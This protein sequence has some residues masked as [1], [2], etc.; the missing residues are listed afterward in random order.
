V[1][2]DD[3]SI[4]GTGDFSSLTSGVTGL[5]QQVTS[6]SAAI[7]ALNK[8]LAAN[9]TVST[10]SASA[11]TSAS[12]ATTAAASSATRAASAAAQVTTQVTAQTTA[13]QASTAAQNANA[14][15]SNLLATA[16]NVVTTSA[17]NAVSGISK[18]N[19]SLDGL[20]KGFDTAAAHGRTLSI[21]FDAIGFNAGESAAKLLAGAGAMASGMKAA[22]G[23]FLAIAAVTVA[24]VGI[25]DF[26]KNS[27]SAA[28]QMQ[29]AMT[30]L[31]TAIDQGGESF[32]ALKPKI[33]AFI[34]LQRQTTTSD[35]E[36]L[37]EAIT[38]LRLAGESTAG[39]MQMVRVAE[40]VAA[41]TG[42]SLL[43]V[44]EALAQAV[45][46]HTRALTSMNVG[47]RDSIKDGMSLHDVLEALEAQYGGQ[48]TSEV[49][50]YRGAH[51][52]LDQAI[53]H[54]QEDIG[55]KLLD[56]LTK[57]TQK[58]TE[59]V[60]S[61]DKD[62]AA[63]IANDIIQIANA[64]VT[65]GTAVKNAD[66]FL[67]SYMSHQQQ[68]DKNDAAAHN[69]NNLQGALSRFFGPGAP[70]PVL[71]NFQEQ[72]LGAVVKAPTFVG[73]DGKPNPGP[74][75]PAQIDQTSNQQVGGKSSEEQAAEAARKAHEA[76]EKNYHDQMSWTEALFANKKISWEAEIA[77]IEKIRETAATSIQEQ[78]ED[79]KMEGEI[80]T[81]GQAKDLENTKKNAEAA[82][83][84]VAT[85]VDFENQ[86]AETA[87]SRSIAL[88]QDQ[89]AAD[90][91]ELASIKKITEES[92]LSAKERSEEMLKYWNLMKEFHANE[93]EAAK[94]AEEARDKQLSDTEA[95]IAVQL[96]LGTIS[97]PQAEQQYLDFATNN[98]G[99]G[100]SDEQLKLAAESKQT[101]DEMV[102]QDNAAADLQ[103]QNAMKVSEDQIDAT[104]KSS[105]ARLALHDQ[106][107]QNTIDELQLEQN[108]QAQIT[109]VDKKEYANREKLI[110]EDTQLI[111]KNQAEIA[112]DYQTYLD[113]ATK[114]T[115]SFIDEV[116]VKHKT[117]KDELQ[118]LYN[119][120]LE[121]YVQMIAKMIV[122]SSL[123]KQAFPW[124]GGSNSGSG[125]NGG[126][127]GA[128][129]SGAS[130]KSGNAPDGSTGSP[131]NVVIASHSPTAL[132]Q[133]TG[134]NTGVSPSSTTAM[135]NSS[136]SSETIDGTTFSAIAGSGMD[137]NG[138]PVSNNG[139]AGGSSPSS[140]AS[141][142]ASAMQAVGLGTV[143]ASVTGGNATYGALGGVAGS[144][145]G[146][147]VGKLF[148]AAGGPIGEIAGSL[149][150][151]VVGGLF[152]PHETAA[153]QPDLNDPT[154][155]TDLAN[156]QGQSVVTGNTTETPTEAN[157]TSNG[158]T[159]ESQQLINWVQSNQNNTSTLTPAQLSLYNQI[160]GLEG[161]NANPTSDVLGITSEHQG[162]A[163]FGSGQ[164]MSVSDF[165]ALVTNFGQTVGTAA[166]EVLAPIFDVEHSLPDYAGSSVNAAGEYTPI[167]TT[168]GTVA[169]SGTAGSSTITDPVADPRATAQA[170]HITVQGS[171]IAGTDL[172]AQLSK[173]LGNNAV[174]N[175]SAGLMDY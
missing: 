72:L 147:M 161:G 69:T 61:I 131:L 55:D 154:W 5:Q 44:T 63:E 7:D 87:H 66:D 57:V 86:A 41:G 163:T 89:T 11:T 40:D 168:G 26:L 64:F 9:Q 73:A 137:V 129:L 121:A 128:F 65:V 67:E 100:A 103:I 74:N 12:T 120:M 116:V 104:K 39:A 42:K 94:R 8:T 21:A 47:T 117:L 107:I 126:V 98:S 51:E 162:V 158:G 124:T 1:A 145:L 159:S 13:V 82:A 43:D 160:L 157:N 22:I 122:E 150:G 18:L 68:V 76:A 110:Q 78:N 24:G 165:E 35:P 173:A 20:S 127:F 99:E 38:R 83:K 52:Q 75:N 77:A 36:Q 54:L 146:D 49:D 138:N 149:L 123:F 144:A 30:K 2:D 15:Q 6:L 25:I 101:H 105:A 114:Q 84:A 171:I 29:T 95:L 167:V 140:I 97:R 28:E 90:N 32:D 96:K 132:G 58:M 10:G 143:G 164:T 170:V 79:Y 152:G 148:G 166:G 111:L 31:K 19:F 17:S 156:W 81:E 134:W 27:V 136:N 62:K 3:I 106:I 4:K 88:G 130:G 33:E 153:D 151:G 93:E 92:G 155:G 71:P 142:V 169:P 118:T 113:D 48:A 109:D 112:Q 70:P 133:T 85:R 172:A 23:P 80:R 174:V 45:H 91:A 53:K 135:L 50:T 56:G 37:V 125:S 119:D 46:G 102:E 59:F 139:S 60:N 141:T 175:T 16:W 115:A 34:E 14:T 108:A